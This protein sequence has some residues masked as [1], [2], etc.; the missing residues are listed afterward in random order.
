MKFQINTGGGRG[1]QLSSKE[2]TSPLGLETGSQASFPVL[3]HP[4]EGWMGLF[5]LPP[6]LPSPVG[7]EQTDQMQHPLTGAHS[8]VGQSWR[9]PYKQLVRYPHL[10]DGKTEARGGRGFSC[11]QTTS[12]R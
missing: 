9:E 10:T 2:E 5:S 6:A 11:C 3:L 4:R 1:L 8:Q 12:Q 7:T